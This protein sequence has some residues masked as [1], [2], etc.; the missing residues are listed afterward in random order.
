MKIY[1]VRHAEKKEEN[2]A[3]PLTKK[4]FKQAKYLARFLK[5]IDID[6]FYCSNF[7]RAKQTAQKV[8]K[9]IKMEP[10][11]EDS[12]NEYQMTSLKKNFKDS[13][14]EELKRLSNLK[15]FIK[16]LTKNP[17]E[18]KSILIIAHGV[19]NRIIVSELMNIEKIKLVG[20]M[21]HETGITKMK[22]N[23]KHKN[24]RVK[25]WSDNSHLPKRLK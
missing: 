23:S 7:L 13:T 11:I 19:T 10:T 18:K 5:K 6:E 14:K 9:K 3:S 22:W 2:S 16:N 20:F 4:G 25:T 8:S 15:K 17:L 1:L 24:W 12:L 21:Q